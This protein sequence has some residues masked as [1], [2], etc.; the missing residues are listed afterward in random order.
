M[1]TEKKNIVEEIREK[2]RTSPFVL[3]TDYTGMSVP[4]FAELRK[5]L[6]ASGA[7][8]TVVKNTMLRIAA[9]ELGLPSVDSWLSG[10]TAIVAG[11]KDVCSAAKVLRNFGSEFAKPKVRGGILDGEVLEATQVDQLAQ[12]PPQDILRA[13]FL[14][15]LQAPATKLV[16]VLGEPG[17]C[18]ARV[19]A[20]RVEK[21]DS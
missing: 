8:Y 13:Q 11:E 12:L 9:K 21:G 15:L 3:V 10:Q 7:R 5:R 17:T 16:R 19:L 14:G 2:I 20:A 1:R 18:L 6:Q 4:Q